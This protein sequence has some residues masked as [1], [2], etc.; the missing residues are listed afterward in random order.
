M[1]QRTF[2]AS[3]CAHNGQHLSLPRLEGQVFKDHKLRTSRAIHL[4]K[5][6]NPQDVCCSDW[7]QSGLPRSL[8]L[9]LA[10]AQ[11]FAYTWV[12]VAS[13]RLPQRRRLA[14]ASRRPAVAGKG[15]VGEKGAEQIADNL[16]RLEMT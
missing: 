16:F 8:F 12:A 5:L 6:L 9:P 7:M 2:A 11:P 3:R 15:R 4:A 1:E 10:A 14:V 13:A